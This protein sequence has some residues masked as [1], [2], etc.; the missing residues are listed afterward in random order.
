MNTQL[1]DS[2]EMREALRVEHTAGQGWID[3]SII[4]FLRE[5]KMA[6]TASPRRWAGP[7]FPA[8]LAT[9]ISPR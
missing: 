4:T 7:D 1:A 5:E 3:L 6:S 2:D 8:V 9:R